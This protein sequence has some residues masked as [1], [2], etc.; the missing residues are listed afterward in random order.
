MDGDKRAN[1][2]YLFSIEI[3]LEKAGKMQIVVTTRNDVRRFA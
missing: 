3:E 1:D 2:Y